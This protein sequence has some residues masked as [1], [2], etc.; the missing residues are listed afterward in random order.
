MISSPPAWSL[1]G[2]SSTTT[3]M[4]T[5]MM[6]MM[7]NRG[8]GALPGKTLRPSRLSTRTSRPLRDKLCKAAAA[9][10]AATST[11]AAVA[12]E[13]RPLEEW[14]VLCAWWGWRRAAQLMARIDFCF[15]AVVRK[16]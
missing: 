5:R 6:T 9:A 2:G 8:T 4:T 16:V 14:V 1:A 11:T 13:A 3:T 12:E 15:V 7:T 10:A